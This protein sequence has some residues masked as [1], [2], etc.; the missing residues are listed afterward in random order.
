MSIALWIVQAL[1]ALGFLAAGFPKLLQPIPTLA[2]MLPWAAQVPVA[3]VRFIGAAEILGAIGIVLPDALYRF[4]VLKVG[5]F[6]ALSVAAAIGLA[7]AMVSAVIFHIARKEYPNMA[8]SAVLFLL[9]LFV[10]IGR[11]TLAPIH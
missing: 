9:A 1:L 4:G 7:V 3:L 11:L 8:P 6:P 2:K 5:F 10:I